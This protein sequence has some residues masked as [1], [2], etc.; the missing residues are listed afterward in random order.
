MSWTAPWLDAFDRPHERAA[1]E[2]VARILGATGRRHDGEGRQGAHDITLTVHSLTIAVEVKRITNSDQEE[3]WT[4]VGRHDWVDESLASSWSVSLRPG[5]PSIK[6]I[7]QELPE[8]LRRLEELSSSP[9]NGWV[10]SQED[11]PDLVGLGIRRV[12]H[13]GPG[14]PGVIYI[15]QI[16][17]GSS[18]GPEIVSR[19]AEGLARQPGVFRK[20][21]RSGMDRY[22]LFLW[23]D[24]FAHAHYAAMELSWLLPGVQPLLP[25]ELD[26]VW[27][28]RS[29]TRSD[30][31]LWADRLWRYGSLGCWED[32]TSPLS[33]LS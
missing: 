31:S 8:V 1:A 13:L 4:A 23:V 3:L 15:S 21:L 22:H 2:I 12:T 16:E 18:P 26:C 24:P 10:V 30:S 20:L 29:V 33:P 11:E 28:A 32:L 14:A 5:A 17:C 6:S 25:R 9:S 27:I 19:T 7:R